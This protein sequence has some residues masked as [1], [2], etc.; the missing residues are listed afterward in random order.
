V[1]KIL[2]WIVGGILALDAVVVA[3]FMICAILLRRPYPRGIDEPTARWILDPVESVEL[4]RRR[5]ERRRGSMHLVKPLDV[6]THRPRRRPAGGRVLAMAVLATTLCAGSVLASPQV[7]HVVASA[8][9]AV[10]GELR[11]TTDAKVAGTDPAALPEPT[12]EPGPAGSPAPPGSTAPHGG[13]G[14]G[15]GVARGH[16]A[17]DAAP[18]VVVEPETPTDLTAVSASS[19]EIDLSWTDVANETGYRVERSV[20]GGTVW[21]PIATSGQDVTSYRDAG[22]VPGTTCSYRIVATNTEGDSPSSAV[23]TATTTVDPA[24]PPT[25][26]A[27]SVSSTQVDLSWT[28]VANETGYRVERSSDGVGGWSA[29]ATPA[30][31]ATTYSDTGLSA[32]TT[33][34]Y[35]VFATNGGGDSPSSDVASATTTAPTST[36]PGEVVPTP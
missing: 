35:R 34:F 8:F 24:S 21:T 26:M 33:Y 3:A 11:S 17:P 10:T 2:L 25:L 36:D 31:D 4:V 7:R 13:S 32:A 20:D 19:T 9:G 28:D 14:L 23:D 18:D 12:S 5:T 1:L 30:Q 16:E 15:S 22:L 27:V 29:I 6:P